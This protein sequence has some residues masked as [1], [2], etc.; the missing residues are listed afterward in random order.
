MHNKEF[1]V[2]PKMGY[3]RIS[4]RFFFGLL[5]IALGGAIASTIMYFKSKKEDE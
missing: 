2:S 5:A 4:K 1:M 3:D